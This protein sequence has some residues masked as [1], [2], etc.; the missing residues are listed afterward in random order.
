MSE[1]KP[2]TKE[3][4]PLSDSHADS[5]KFLQQENGYKEI[6]DAIGIEAFNNNLKELQ[7]ALGNTF[8]PLFNIWNKRKF[9]LSLILELST[10]IISIV[11][12]PQLADMVLD[13]M[14]K[15]PSTA[16]ARI[17]VNNYWIVANYDQRELTDKFGLKTE[18]VEFPLPQEEIDALHENL[19]IFR[20]H[21]DAYSKFSQKELLETFK[22][23][24][25]QIQGDQNKKSEE[26]NS[27]P[28]INLKVLAILYLLF[29]EE[30]HFS[31]TT[32]QLTTALAIINKP[33]ARR[34]MHIKQH[35]DRV[36]VGLLV[37]CYSASIKPLEFIEPNAS[38]R[39]TFY[40]FYQKLP[41]FQLSMYDEFALE[42]LPNLMD[43]DYQPNS[44][45][46]QNLIPTDVF[47]W[48]DPCRIIVNFKAHKGLTVLEDSE[49]RIDLEDEDF[50]KIWTYIKKH[51]SNKTAEA[52]INDII[53]YITKKF[54]DFVSEDDEGASKL[55]KIGYAVFTDQY[56]NHSDY[57]IDWTRKKV[58]L[59]NKPELNL[60]PLGLVEFITL[61]NKLELYNPVGI[62]GCISFPNYINLYTNVFGI[63]ENNTP[64]IQQ[65]LKTYNNIDIF[66]VP[67]PFPNNV[68]VLPPILVADQKITV[69]TKEQKS[70]K[71][72]N[73]FDITLTNYVNTAIS[74]QRPVILLCENENQSLSYY[75]K[76]AALTKNIGILNYSYFNNILAGFPGRITIINCEA[77][78]E[79]QFVL[80]AQAEKN[81]GFATICVFLPEH[82]HTEQAIFDYSSRFGTKGSAVYMIDE[83]QLISKISALSG[84]K[85]EPSSLPLP[86]LFEKWKTA[87]ELA[88]LKFFEHHQ[89]QY[90]LG[91]QLFQAQRCYF[92]LPNLEK[93]IFLRTYWGHCLAD[94]INNIHDKATP[95]Y[96]DRVI[97]THL[98]HFWSF[99]KKNNSP[100]FQQTSL[101][102]HAHN[103]KNEYLIN[104]F[105]RYKAFPVNSSIEEQKKE[106]ISGNLSSENSIPANIA[107]ENFSVKGFKTYT[108]EKK[109]LPKEPN[110]LDHF[111]AYER[112]VKE[113][114]NS[115]PDAIKLADDFFT[116]LFY[117]QQV[118]TENNQTHLASAM[119]LIANIFTVVNNGNG[120]FLFDL[121][122]SIL[123]YF[124][125]NLS[126]INRDLDFAKK[127][128]T[129]LQAILYQEGFETLAKEQQSEII[130]SK[131]RIFFSTIKNL[132]TKNILPKG[133]KNLEEF[134]L[135]FYRDQEINRAGFSSCA[136]LFQ[137]DAVF[138]LADIPL[139]KVR[140][141]D[142]EKTHQA[143]ASSS[144][145]QEILSAAKTKLG[146]DNFLKLQ[147][148]LFHNARLTL[149]QIL[150][151]NQNVS[152]LDNLH[153]F[154][155]FL[156][157]TKIYSF[158]FI[159]VA[160][161]N[162]IMQASQEHAA[163]KMD[164]VTLFS[165]PTSAVRFPLSQEE[166]RNINEAYQS[167]LSRATYLTFYNEHKLA[168]YIRELRTKTHK[169]ESK[170]SAQS[171]N[172]NLLTA[173]REL[174]RKVYGFY[175]TDIQMFN[176]LAILS[177]KKGRRI[178]QIKPNEGGAIVTLM[179][180]SYLA[181]S[182]QVNLICESEKSI[183]RDFYDY[184][185]IFTNFSN[186]M[187]VILATKHGNMPILDARINFG[188]IPSFNRCYLSQQIGAQDFQTYTGPT[189]TI[190]DVAA[191]VNSLVPFERT[192][193]FYTEFS[194]SD[195]SQESP[196]VYK[197]IWE[198]ISKEKPE[199][200][201]L[202]KQF[203]IKNYGQRN[204]S[205]TRIQRWWH[206]AH[207]LLAKQEFKKEMI[208]DMILEGLWYDG[209]REFEA[210]KNNANIVPNVMAALFQGEYFNLV[211]NVFGVNNYISPE[212]REILET[213]H[214]IEAYD[215]P[216][217]W[218]NQ[219]QILRPIII[220]NKDS[221]LTE[222]T[223]EPNVTKKDAVI[224]CV[225][226]LVIAGRPSL[227]VCETTEQAREIFSLFSPQRMQLF[228]ETVCATEVSVK[229]GLPGMVTIVTLDKISQLDIRLSPKAKSNGGMEVMVLFPLANKAHEDLIFN[230]ASHC[231]SK[232]SA[233]YILNEDELFRNLVNA[234]IHTAHF[235]LN[236]P[237]G[238]QLFL[239]WQQFRDAR[240]LI[241]NRKSN[242]EMDTNN[243]VLNIFLNLPMEIKKNSLYRD[244]WRYH[245]YKF[246]F[247]FRHHNEKNKFACQFLNDFWADC[248]KAN[249]DSYFA[250]NTLLQHAMNTGNSHVVSI[251]TKHL[252][253][254][255]TQQSIQD[256]TTLT[257][258]Q[259]TSKLP[260]PSLLQ[261]LVYMTHTPAEIKSEKLQSSTLVHSKWQP[262]KVESVSIQTTTSSYSVVK[263]GT[264][265]SPPENK[266]S[267]TK[268]HNLQSSTLV[269]SKW[270]P[271][272]S[273]T[274]SVHV[275]TSSSSVLET[276]TNVSKPK[277]K[278]P[279]NV[280]NGPKNAQ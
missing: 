40:D 96:L 188:D 210:A 250:S 107:A 265:V 99:A 218:E 186:L 214:N 156:T 251:I 45:P 9:S 184:D 85:I 179:L 98:N 195:Y 163:Q 235:S 44:A 12:Y 104:I 161:D 187:R 146:Q 142:F 139:V 207:K 38:V 257:A 91:Q 177:H 118:I 256:Q 165:Q 219:I 268:S 115:A 212:M 252:P 25:L 246:F 248:V 11:K 204:F 172:L 253:E 48:H 232:G 202:L 82:L 271:Q 123:D 274:A 125:K 181:C 28:T 121:R 174:I 116:S 133:C 267:E 196:L 231:G 2:E 47:V 108:L 151:I 106:A 276:N 162:F 88:T 185:P 208:P 153:N 1:F 19:K 114:K 78:T 90:K 203:L 65:Q 15:A 176:V 145:F 86:K 21:F 194:S 27:A 261:D 168:H 103:I 77:F 226:D 266:P 132:L 270:K 189:K 178:A 131:V 52:A 148:N 3:K 26:K 143:F 61:K 169:L 241:R 60:I 92:D 272:K 59:L 273:E 51:S 200:I 10:K 129:A 101:L 4:R 17:A 264:E 171:L 111:F 201:E 193:R 255:L 63:I 22:I 122:V 223:D 215:S 5:L 34:L 30:Y 20:L 239:L 180:T 160:L 7:K 262:P 164:L 190:A 234:S 89:Q 67:S 64:A 244:L 74:K 182:Q 138:T 102:Q 230:C 75:K 126:N 134:R 117:L 112:C 150:Y 228:T 50:I 120:K 224:S 79:P 240:N 236:K 238:T 113:Y 128:I 136:H 155:A 278:K 269:H 245:W 42:F 191:I 6:I 211:G 249:R 72:I 97:N 53:N 209:V 54:P 119:T 8:T 149:P 258:L 58:F 18:D 80:T 83:L 222:S 32:H 229:A 279:K 216:S 141:E 280:T 199:S 227:L 213:C 56:K 260:Q 220:A 95:L 275:M 71:T 221:E 130:K 167:I 109:S 93:N 49:D 147:H 87:R 154:N 43:S 33:N 55:A 158:E 110:L 14:A 233:R 29:R 81:G 84:E 197:G 242:L 135:N 225:T 124:D 277:K 23:Q 243:A 247:H 159:K 175:P 31:P 24:V 173:C 259:A 35:E 76:L 157:V 16:I 46:P 217:F 39:N 73:T 198:F 254:L 205:E 41:L 137:N 127:F 263:T 152:Y 183:L 144:E 206:A 70:E 166:V 68:E 66:S 100:Y 192:N 105:E 140:I 37:A 36:M 62:E 237:S 94:I 57:I 170:N 13:A 69:E